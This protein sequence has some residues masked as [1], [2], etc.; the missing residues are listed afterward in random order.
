MKSKQSLGHLNGK[1]LPSSGSRLG[2]PEVDLL[3]VF[4]ARC[5]PSWKTRSKEDLPCAIPAF[6]KNG[7]Q[8][9]QPSKKTKGGTV[10]KSPSTLAEGLISEELHLP[11]KTFSFS[12]NVLQKSFYSLPP[13]PSKNAAGKKD[14]PFSYRI[15]IGSRFSP[16]I[17]KGVAAIYNL[18][19]FPLNWQL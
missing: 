3:N 5:L 16:S 15:N 2:F 8:V 17:A 1:F 4:L 12:P 14:L 9:R 6:T 11:S 18:I 19:F 7:L 10:F 13:S